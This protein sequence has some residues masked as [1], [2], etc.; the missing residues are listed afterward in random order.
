LIDDQ[1]FTML[2]ANVNP[3]RLHVARISENDLLGRRGEA[4]RLCEAADAR[5]NLWFA[6]PGCRIQRSYSLGAG[7]NRQ[8]SLSTSFTGFFCFDKNTTTRNPS[9]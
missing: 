3:R 9:V 8:G 2:A 5:F 4:A 6:G 1:Q 7:G